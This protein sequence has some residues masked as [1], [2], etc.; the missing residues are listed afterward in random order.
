VSAHEKPASFYSSPA[1]AQKAP[2]EDYLYVT[3]MRVGTGVDA[4]DLLAVVDTNPASDTYGQIVH[5]TPMPYV[6]D[7]LHHFG[8][9]RC[10]SACHGPDR[11]HLIVPGFRS[12]RVY[13]VNVADEPRR[14]RIEKVIEPGELLKATGYTRPH[15][16]HCMPGDNVVVSMLGDAE[17]KAAGG[18]AV[19][20]AKTFELKGRWEN[21]GAVPP[22]NYDF[23][24]QPRKNTLVSSEFG[25]PN[26]Y[27]PGFDLGDVQAGRYGQRLHFWNLA[28]RTL[29]QTVDLG[30]TGLVPLEIRWKHDPEADEG[31]VGAALS[32]TMWRFNRENGSYATERVIS[33]DS[34]ELAGWPIPVPGLI[35]D[36]VLSVDDKALYFSN[37]LH[38][39]LRRYDVSD[40]S[41]PRLTGRLWLGGVLGKET[42][43]GRPLTGGPQM[44]QLSL[45]GRRLYVTNSLYSTWDNQFYPGLRSWMLKVDV[46]EDGTMSVDPGFFVDFHDRVDGPVRA[47]EMRLQGGDV[48][49]EVY[50]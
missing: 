47:H 14:P 33:V 1:E 31:F 35:T 6:G 27:E 5:E 42:D 50:P 21:G 23:W 39:D 32:S 24:Y 48:T 17:G 41:N 36:L 49:S 12:S 29:E 10:S 18:F 20:D 30:E 9:N 25:E 43:A 26:A 4:P 22:M 3:A 7:E 46:G 16:T 38:G 13:V 45:D 37:W 44:L 11:S 40:P 19:I 2:P 8:W 28:E 34:V 15:T